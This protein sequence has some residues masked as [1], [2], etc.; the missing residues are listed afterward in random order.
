M[1]GRLVVI[2]TLTV[3]NI[4]GTNYCSDTYL[5]MFVVRCL[6]TIICLHKEAAVLV[7]YR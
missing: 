7:D 6:L 5:I 2:I 4:T 3:A 1:C